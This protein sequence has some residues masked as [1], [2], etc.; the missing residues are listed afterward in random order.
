MHGVTW[1]RHAWCHVVASCM[2]GADMASRMATQSL[3]YDT[4]YLSTRFDIWKML[5]IYMMLNVY[6][7]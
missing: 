4:P 6:H 2:A 5:V 1:W 7:K 3:S